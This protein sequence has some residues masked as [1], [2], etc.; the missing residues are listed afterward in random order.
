MSK[1]K[2]LEQ[3]RW[4][5][6]HVPDWTVVSP[7]IVLDPANSGPY[8]VEKPTS[9]HRG[10][11]FDAV[12]CYDEAMPRHQD[13][14]LLLGLVEHHSIDLGQTIDVEKHRSVGSISHE[15][16]GYID[17]LNALA[18]RV[19]DLSLPENENLFSYLIVRGIIKATTTGHWRAAIREIR[20]LQHAE[21]LPQ[22][23]FRN[24]SGYGAGRQQRH[25]NFA[26]LADSNRRV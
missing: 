23:F 8:V 7:D 1:A 13:R 21:T 3:L 22:G 24:L 16:D 11:A 9:G 20:R 4:V 10:A 12:G 5:G 19:P 14:E 26:K 15:F 6:I 17:G 25:R 18:Q 2:E